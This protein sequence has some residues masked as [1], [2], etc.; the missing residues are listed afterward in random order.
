MNLPRHAMLAAAL[1]TSACQL[2]VQPDIYLSDVAAVRADGKSIPAMALVS[3][4]VPSEEKCAEAAGT[5]AAPLA[6]AFA[7]AEYKGCR[8]V[9]FSTLADFTVTTDM[10]REVANDAYDSERP[11]YIGVFDE[12]D[13]SHSISVYQNGDALKALIEK[14]KEASDA[15]VNRVKYRVSAR[16]VNDTAG[17]VS[18]SV[19]NVF[20]DG[21][22]KPYPVDIELDRRA[23]AVIATSDVVNTAFGLGAWATIARVK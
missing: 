12:G 17:P 2:G 7:K 23:E 9:E 5:L 21:Q 4:E 22:P 18:L 6:E 15:P 10:V 20:V 11:I 3:F 13:G 19:S 8:K 1:A 14:I 16:V